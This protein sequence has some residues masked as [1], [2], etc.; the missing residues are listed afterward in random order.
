MMKICSKR[1]AQQKPEVVSSR[2]RSSRASH[3]PCCNRRGNHKPRWIMVDRLGH[4]AY[5]IF[6]K[7]IKQYIIQNHRVYIVYRYT[8][9]APDF[10]C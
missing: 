3:H 6:V 7:A 8:Y 9:I 1:G 5:H 2:R 10:F 4:I